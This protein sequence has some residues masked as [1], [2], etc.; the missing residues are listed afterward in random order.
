MMMYARPVMGPVRAFSG[1]EIT[2]FRL[3]FFITGALAGENPKENRIKT[4]QKNFRRPSKEYLK[5]I[6]LLCL[7]KLKALTQY[8]INA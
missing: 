7:E 4:T 2:N 3:E 6:L 8:R 5:F 1:K